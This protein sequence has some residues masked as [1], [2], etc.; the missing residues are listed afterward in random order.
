M[1]LTLFIILLCQILPLYSSSQTDQTL[2][3]FTYYGAQ[4]G[5]NIAF[6]DQLSNG[7]IVSVGIGYDSGLAAGDD[8][9]QSFSNGEGDVFLA[10]WSSDGELI[11]GTYFGGEAIELVE[12]IVID[13]D[14]NILIAGLTHSSD[15]IA[16]GDS[17]L[18]EFLGYNC[19]FLAKFNQEGQILWSTYI[20]GE[21]ADFIADL[22][23]DSSNNIYV[24]GG[25]TSENLSEL[26]EYQGDGDA[27][28]ARYSPDGT[29]EWLKYRG[30][31]MDERGR[32]ISINS[33]DEI[34]I[35]FATK[36]QETLASADAE[37]TTGGGDWSLILERLNLAGDV[38]WSRYIG[39][40]GKESIGHVVSTENE[41]YLLGSTNSDN[42]IGTDGAFEPE[43]LVGGT[44]MSFYLNKFSTDGIKVWGTYFGFGFISDVL[45]RSSALEI[46]DGN[47][48][49]MSTLGSII[50]EGFVF[51]DNPFQ[52]DAQSKDLIVMKWGFDGLPV[53]GTRFGGNE[54][55]DFGAL[56]VSQDGSKI[57]LGGQTESDEFYGLESSF[58]GEYGGGFSDM[59]LAKLSDQTL[60]VTNF[61]K[62]SQ[63]AVYPNPVA[64]DGVLQITSD[65]DIQRA[66]LY[67]TEG[68]IIETWDILSREAKLDLA[69]LQTGV[70]ILKIQTAE[71]IGVKRIVI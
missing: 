38:A 52:S 28:I 70:Y 59:F 45:Q 60:G 47:V 41:I 36:D 27:I 44:N 17:D 40:D 29:K 64:Q 37:Q 61:L 48:Y 57:I 23:I 54:P 5:E 20:G 66:V 32:S 68:R 50:F 56:C 22:A 9:H 34:Y 6:I 42:N 4:G 65:F 3:W 1:R 69:S 12:G 30:G 26:N 49:V 16:F 8:I 46:S 71:G 18:D 43:R 53:W 2:D 11:W 55:E 62:P 67:N 31:N 14:D 21:N 39:G 35:L 33:N 19:G 58:Q 15:H 51:G 7:S 63:F 25:S 13:Q 24:L 10:L